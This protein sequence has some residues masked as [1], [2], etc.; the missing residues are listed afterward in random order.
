MSIRPILT[1][2][3][4]RLT[5]PCAEVGEV[6]AQVQIL[7]ADML[8]TMYAA[9]GVGWPGRRLARCCGFS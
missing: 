2:P 5:Q 1:W 3:D 4:A 8:E 7:A 6:T 9:P